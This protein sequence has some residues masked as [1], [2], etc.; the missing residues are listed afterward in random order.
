MYLLLFN[1]KRKDGSAHVLHAQRKDTA[2]KSV[3]N[4][5]LSSIRRILEAEGGLQT[6]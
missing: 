4:K 2:Q 1:R 3:V 6:F 5:T